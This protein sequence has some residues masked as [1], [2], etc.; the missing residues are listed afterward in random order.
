M[1]AD[2]TGLESSHNAVRTVSMQMRNLEN[3]ESDAILMDGILRLWSTNDPVTGKV[4]I[5]GEM[6]R[7]ERSRDML[8]RL[9]TILSDPQDVQIIF[10]FLHHGVLAN[11]VNWYNYAMRDRKL[12]TASVD[13]YISK[14]KDIGK[15]FHRS[16][17][18]SIPKWK[19][20]FA[21]LTP[22]CNAFHISK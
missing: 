14:A 22:I 2:K 5:I 15:E 7:Y 9:R 4:L 10:D 19:E 18:D 12:S 3:H 6:S 16:R 8:D 21:K 1:S 11:Y 13:G 20:A 17:F